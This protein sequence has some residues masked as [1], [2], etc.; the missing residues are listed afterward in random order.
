MPPMQFRMLVLPAPLGPMRAS[1]SPGCTSNDT[2]AS[3]RRPPKDSDSCSTRSAG[4]AIPAPAPPVL[5]DVAV[6]APRAAG[7]AEV[8]LADVL[9]GQQAL[10]RAVE[11]DPSV[12]HDVGVVGGVERDLGVLL[13]EQDRHAEAA[14]DR[15]QPRHQL[16]D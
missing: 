13:D 4:S 3:T 7:G 12:L 10:G 9:V 6:A 16:L 5:L 11:D 14:A 8:E 2:R 1:S 15:L